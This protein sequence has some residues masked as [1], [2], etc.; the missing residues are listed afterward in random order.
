MIG[1]AVICVV[2]DL[3]D[4]R[5]GVEPSGGPRAGSPR[6]SGFGAPNGYSEIS[7]RGDS[8]REPHHAYLA[9]WTYI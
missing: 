7:H 5:Y 9:I 6:R 3:L 1:F 4:T 2:F 8:E